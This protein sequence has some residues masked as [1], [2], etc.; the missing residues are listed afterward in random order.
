MKEKKEWLLEVCEIFTSVQGE[1]YNQGRPSHFI[2]LSRC[3]MFCPF[4]DSKYS[5]KDGSFYDYQGMSAK[6]F[7]LKKQFPKIN[8]VTISGGE[9]L[10]QNIK[11]LVEILNEYDFDIEIETNGLVPS[12]R[13]IPNLNCD[14][15][16]I[17]S[18]KLLSEDII[19]K[20]T[21][22]KLKFFL[23]R[24]HIF[25][26]VIGTMQELDTV[27]DFIKRLKLEENNSKIYLMPK[28]T[29]VKEIRKSSKLLTP[30]C[31]DKGWNLSDR[32]QVVIWGNKRGI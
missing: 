23:D 5:W 2:R 4:C 29:S 1:G 12:I 16:F 19:K 14:D 20:Y 26:F 31:L 13:N 17:V 18:P 10:L 32:Q 11:P 6:L 28:G 7:I 24:N 9:P 25:K 27:L 3:N 15:I 8:L 21:R 22:R 30:I